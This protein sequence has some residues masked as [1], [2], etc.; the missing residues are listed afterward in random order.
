MIT[1]LRMA[2]YLHARPFSLYPYS[3]ESFVRSE[4]LTHYGRYNYW[5]YVHG[6]SIPPSNPYVY[7][8][9][10]E[11]E[12]I[13]SFYVRLKNILFPMYGFTTDMQIVS[14]SSFDSSPFTVYILDDIANERSLR[15]ASIFD[16]LGLSFDSEL[17]FYQVMNDF[18]GLNYYLDAYGDPLG[19]VFTL[20]TFDISM[21]GLLE[22]YSYTY[23]DDAL[24]D[25]N[26]TILETFLGVNNAIL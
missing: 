26:I 3:N 16:F 4:Y 9:Q 18:L 17:S 22:Y 21:L 11:G 12:T 8:K 20:D 6:L 14:V 7:E 10:F 15:V 23:N 13:D 25:Q 24:I 1:N 19:S 2:Q 5:G